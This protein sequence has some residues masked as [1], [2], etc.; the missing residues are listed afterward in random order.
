[1]GVGGI[2]NEPFEKHSQG[3]PVWGFA[4]ILIE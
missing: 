1:M 4:G 2:K 3:F